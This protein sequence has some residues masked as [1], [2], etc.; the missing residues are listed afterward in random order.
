M[1]QKAVVF[2]FPFRWKPFSP[3]Q[4]NTVRHFGSDATALF[5]PPGGTI[6]SVREA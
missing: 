4:F 1:G 6:P 3:L 2:Y 5:P